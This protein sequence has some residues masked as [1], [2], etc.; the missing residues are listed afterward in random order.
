MRRFCRM[1][2]RA[3]SRSLHDV[4]GAWGAPQRKKGKG[5]ATAGSS[6][7]G[8]GPFTKAAA[9]AGSSGQGSSSQGSSRPSAPP[10]RIIGLSTEE[11]AVQVA[12]PATS[13]QQTEPEPQPAGGGGTKKDKERLRKERQRQRKIEEASEALDR[14][15]ALLAETRGSVEAVEEAMQAADKHDGRSEPLAALVA[16]AKGMVEQAQAAEAERARVAAEAAAVKAGVEAVAE[17]AEAAERLQ[18]EQELAA[19]TLSVQSDARRVQSD[20]LR[21]QQMQARLGVP[22]A[23]PTPH[24]DAEETM[25]VVCFDAPKDHIIVPCGHMCVCEACAE[26]LTKTRTPSC[27]VCRKPIRETVKVFCT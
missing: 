23:A 21:V 27:P 9:A 16:E 17:A 22:P 10:A 12:Q 5:K 25:C 14:A 15:M 18:M 2:E 4:L 6:G 7:A 3:P 8:G 26:Q 1:G 24:P 19:L 11:P 20:R 13:A